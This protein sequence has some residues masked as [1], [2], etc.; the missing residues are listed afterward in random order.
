[1]KLIIIW[2]GINLIFV[3]LLTRRA[4][5]KWN[6]GINV[7]KEGMSIKYSNVGVRSLKGKGKIE[8]IYK[9]FILIDAGKYKITIN[10]GDI[11]ANDTIVEVKID[12]KWVELN[13]GMLG[14]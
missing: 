12:K 1:M 4:N 9:S 2:L 11:I 8:K 7:V 14:F 6:G 3:L 13:R 10:K 5:R